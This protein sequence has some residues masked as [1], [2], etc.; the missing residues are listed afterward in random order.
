M[1]VIDLLIIVA[2][3]VAFEVTEYLNRFEV[4]K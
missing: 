3:V 1:W 4:G 2:A